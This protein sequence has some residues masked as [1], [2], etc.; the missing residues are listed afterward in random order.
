MVSQLHLT[1]LPE[2][3]MARL[4]LFFLLVVHQAATLVCMRLS[5]L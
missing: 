4:N 2:P 1:F 5:R 3:R